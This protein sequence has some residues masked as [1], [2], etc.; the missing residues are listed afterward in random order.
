MLSHLIRKEILDHILSFRFLVLSITG[1]LAI[2]LSLFSGYTYYQLRLRDYR[3]ARSASEE[4]IQQIQVMG[5][6]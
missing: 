1:T 6:G 3:L 5:T 2:W 4:R